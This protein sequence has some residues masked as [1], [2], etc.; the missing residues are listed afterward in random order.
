[1]SL[2]YFLVIEPCIAS[3]LSPPS[4]PFMAVLERELIILTFV[5]LGWAYV[6]ILLL[7]P[8]VI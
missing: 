7:L 5:S 6:L 3:F 8:S 1:M 2:I 4:D